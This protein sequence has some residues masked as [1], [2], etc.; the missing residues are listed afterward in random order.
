MADWCVISAVNDEGVLKKNLASSPML[1]MHP[2]RLTVLRDYPSAGHAY[3]SGLSK[4][5]ARICI[6]AHQDVYLPSGWD[7]RLSARVKQLDTLNPMWA[8]AGPFGISRSGMHCGRVWTTGLGREIGTSPTTPIPAQ[9]L[10][11]LLIILNRDSGLEFDAD[12]PSFHLYGTDIAQTALT[13]GNKVYV[14]DAPVIHNSRPVVTLEGGF[15][16][17]LLYLRHKWHQRLPIRTP[18]TYI[19][20][21]GIRHLLQRMRMR[22]WPRRRD[23]KSRP[24]APV[25]SPIEIAKDLGYE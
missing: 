13:A 19:T 14:I 23:P 21:F 16:D 1:R 12:L 10:D 5:T 2:E 7:T 15:E 18:V 9:S 17:A 6:F 22:D 25:R 8:V 11:E 4:T 20:R 24:A 3:N